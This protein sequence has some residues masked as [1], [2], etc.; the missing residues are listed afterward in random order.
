M[1]DY[2]HTYRT[3]SG[4]MSEKDQKNT[5]ENN[6]EEQS[7]VTEDV[8]EDKEEKR[9]KAR[10]R[11]LTAAGIVSSGTLMEWHRPVIEHVMAPAHAGVSN[12]APTPRPTPKP[13]QSSFSPTPDPTVSPT[14]D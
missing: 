2:F 12:G 3:E 5:G 9:R 13:T 6:P 4:F 7:G 1:L 10:R 8:T 11:M 14:P